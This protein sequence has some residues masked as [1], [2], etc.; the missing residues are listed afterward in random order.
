M[1]VNAFKI[2]PA[3][4]AGGGEFRWPSFRARG[5]KEKTFLALRQYEAPQK[6]SLLALSALRISAIQAKMAAAPDTGAQP[7]PQSIPNI[8]CPSFTPPR[9]R[10]GPSL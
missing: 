4:G 9:I 2:G 7:C 10:A 8:A 1:G 3:T 5:R 6:K